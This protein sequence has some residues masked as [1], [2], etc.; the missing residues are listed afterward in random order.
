MFFLVLCPIL[1]QQPFVSQALPPFLTDFQS[2]YPEDFSSFLGPSKRHF[3]FSHQQPS[4]ED[5]A[6]YYSSYNKGENPRHEGDLREK[7]GQLAPGIYD[8]DSRSEYADSNFLKSLNGEQMKVTGGNGAMGAYNNYPVSVIPGHTDKISP[9][10]DDSQFDQSDSSSNSDVMNEIDEQLAAAMGE[11]QGSADDGGEGASAMNPYPTPPN[12][13]P[14]PYPDEEGKVKPFTIV[15]GC[16][17]KWVDDAELSKWFQD[18]QVGKSD[19]EH[20]Q[21]A[22]KGHVKKSLESANEI[23]HQFPHY[24]KAEEKRDTIKMKKGH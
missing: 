11:G 7:F 23:S 13:C 1:L 8:L 16:V 2:P 12:P 14:L 6:R 4:H 20:N 15:N 5:L 10:N 9:P 17:P 3:Q 22:D 18:Q 19:S 21:G 24:I